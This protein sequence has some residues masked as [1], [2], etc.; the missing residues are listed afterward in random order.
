MIEIFIC[1]IKQCTCGLCGYSWQTLSKYPPM[2]LP[3]LPIAAMEWQETH[4]P[5]T[6]RAD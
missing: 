2:H 5:A 6:D 1:E 3:K 4:G